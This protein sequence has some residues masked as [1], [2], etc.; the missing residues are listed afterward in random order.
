M[1]IEKLAVK[2]GDKS[3]H[4]I[5]RHENVAQEITRECK[6]NEKMNKTPKNY[7]D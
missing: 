3:V 2:E 1:I 6:G 5:V 4:E 7:C